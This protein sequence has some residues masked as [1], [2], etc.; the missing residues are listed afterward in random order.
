MQGDNVPHLFHGLVIETV[1]YEVREYKVGAGVQLYLLDVHPFEYLLGS[2]G[3]VVPG[4]DSDYG[5]LV[6]RVEVR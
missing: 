5:N 6:V 2:E 4:V 1:L 3:I